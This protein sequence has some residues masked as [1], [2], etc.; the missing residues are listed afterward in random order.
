M[1]QDVCTVCPGATVPNVDGDVAVPVQPAGPVSV[2]WTLV[3]VAGPV[4]GNEVV[5]VTVAPGATNEGAVS[6]SGCLMT[7]GAVPVTPLTV[8]LMS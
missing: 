5:A 3:S 6:V 1:D 7:N 4:S 8:T 2:I